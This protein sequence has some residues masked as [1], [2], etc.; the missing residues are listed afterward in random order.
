MISLLWEPLFA[1]AQRPIA[2]IWQL[3]SLKS[4]LALRCWAG[5]S[6]PLPLQVAVEHCRSRHQSWKRETLL[7]DLGV[8]TLPCQYYSK[9]LNETQKE[10]KSKLSEMPKRSKSLDW[11]SLGGLWGPGNWLLLLANWEKEISFRKRRFGTQIARGW[12]G[13]NKMGSWGGSRD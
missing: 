10:R 11:R 9:N 4:L 8:L 12:E 2:T 13:W 6:L 5:Q 7:D 1:H 3:Q